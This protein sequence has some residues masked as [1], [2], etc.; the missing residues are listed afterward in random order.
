MREDWSPYER[1]V[2]HTED[3]VRKVLESVH[4]NGH[5][6]T[7][8]CAQYIRRNYFW[9]GMKADVKKYCKSCEV[10]QCR[11]LAR[12]NVV[13]NLGRIVATRKN[14]LIGIDLFSGIPEDPINKFKYI[15]VITD[16][17][18]KYT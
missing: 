12:K 11:I 6:S 15:L 10:C 16:Y 14:E 13:G 9:Q 4:N 3:E 17:A 1:K 8:K 2:L 18:T 7:K 5:F